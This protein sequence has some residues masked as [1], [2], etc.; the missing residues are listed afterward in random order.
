MWGYIAPAVLGVPNAQRGGEIRSGYL[1]PAISGPACGQSGYI[2]PAAGQRWVQQGPQGGKKKIFSSGVPGPRGML[3]QMFFARFEPVVTR[4]GAWKIPKCLENGPFWDQRWVKKGSKTR[5]SN[6]AR[7][8]GGVL[9]ENTTGSLQSCRAPVQ[10]L[11][12]RAVACTRLR[13]APMGVR[14]YKKP[15]VPA[16]RGRE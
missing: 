11:L 9:E 16:I 12:R 7:G 15:L 1:T 10:P 13:N 2:A 14:T 4:S 8:G 5:F 3:K 6:V